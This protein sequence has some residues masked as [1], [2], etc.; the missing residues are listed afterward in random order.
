MVIKGNGKVSVITLSYKEQNVVGSH[1]LPCHVG[2]RLRKKNVQGY[3]KGLFILAILKFTA[4]H[5]L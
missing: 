1:D 5:A 4:V 3:C 2:T